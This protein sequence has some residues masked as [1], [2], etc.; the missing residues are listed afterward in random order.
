MKLLQKPQLNANFNTIVLLLCS[1]TFG[2]SH[3]SVHVKSLAGTDDHKSDDRL[4]LIAFKNEITQDP[5][6]ILSSWNDKNNS[7]HFCEW[8]GVIC[9]RRHPS[10]VTVL[11][12]DSQGLAGSISP[13]IGNLSFLKE[14]ILSNNSLSGEIPEEIGHL[15]RLKGLGLDNNSLEGEIPQNISRCSNLIHL[16]ISGNNLGGSIP[17]D[18][19]YLSNLIILKFYDNNLSGEIPTSLGNLSSLTLLSLGENNLEGKI[20]TTLSHLTNLVLLGLGLNRLS[21]IVPSSLYNIS[22]LGTIELMDNKL[23]GSIPS[24]IG[25]TLPNLNYFSFSINNLAGNVPSSFSN[26][27]RL[28]ILQLG[29][30]N[31]VGS[32]PYDLCNSKSLTRLQLR[33]NNLGSGQANDLNFLDSLI[34]CT[35]LGFIGLDSNNF[36]GVLPSSMANLTTKLDTIDFRDNQIHGNVP[37]GIQ[38]LVGLTALILQD[39]MFTGSIP[40]GIGNLQNL[41]N[42]DIRKNKFS[43]SIPSSLGNLTRLINLF[44]LFNNLTGR[45]PSSLGNCTSLQNLSLQNN[46]LS[47][48]IPKQVFQLPSLANYFSLSNNL[49]T[50]SLPAEVG[51]LNNIGI[52]DLSENRLSGEI[53]S[54]IGQCVS[55][56]Y[57]DLRGNL[58]QGNIPP[59]I[60]SLKGL[61]RLSLARNNLS[62]IIPKGLESFTTLNLLDLSYN[63]LEGEVPKVGV[64]QNISALSVQ[65]NSKL[66]GGIPDLKL[67]NCSMPL[68][69]DN[70]RKQRKS[71]P[72]KVIIIII[73]LFTLPVFILTLYWRRK[74]RIRQP[75]TTSDVGNRYIGVSYN[76]LVKATDGFN[77]S[78]NLLGV[79]SFGS[80]YRGILQQNEFKPVAVKVL[81]LQQR[82]AAKSFMAECDALRKV[83]HRNLLK[84][85]TCCSSIDFQGN[86]FKALVFEFMA[87]GSLENW[88]HP[89][90]GVA[91]DD[92]HLK[93]RYLNPEKRL[94]IAVDVASA[95]NYLHND[96]ESP[97]VHCDLKPSNVLL[98]DYLVA[99]VGDFGL[100]KFLSNTSSSSWQLNEQDASSIAI[101]GSIGYISPEY[102]MGGEVSTKGDVYSYGILLLEM[103][104]GKRPTDDMFKD[105][106]NIHNFCKMYE[107]PELVEEIIDLRLLLDVEGGNGRDTIRQILASI[108]QI[109]VKCSSETPS[110][111][112]S[113][114]EVTL[115]V[116]AV[117]NRYLDIGM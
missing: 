19:G 22:S 86:P 71:I 11:D 83:R 80:V 108:I 112:S 69:P 95:L 54:T 105:G 3:M 107:F 114:N 77:D 17:N 27:S 56:I 57:L 110:D 101:K 66:C 50:G 45:I 79:G 39:N 64:F 8:R 16:N 53:P 41:R 72:L 60:T 7:L 61:E 73:V 30:N 12:L 109:G 9:S 49:L 47:G 31:L 59:A 28:E 70:K 26:L 98:D 102:G 106:L 117:R 20:P 82:G 52:F 14:L 40:P 85:V 23:H 76:E 111:R 37:A 91:D 34:N 15:S 46:R 88:L 38:N 35:N 81:H 13:H 87:N 68:N 74:S 103:F 116:E 51:N 36:G 84:I 92:D 6:G 115:D 55:L 99:R 1:F 29:E 96:C 100:S 43:G 10:R 93:M 21:G 94:S 2:I 4:A 62:G 5:L 65:G 44:L 63:N 75:S 113:M 42:L 33:A 97:I 89:T 78:T 48:S 24:D 67:Q 32:V 104:T 25:L 18:F 58:F 90:M